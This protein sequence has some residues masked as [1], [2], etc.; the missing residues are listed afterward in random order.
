LATAITYATGAIRASIVNA[1]AIGRT[2]FRGQTPSASHSTGWG[3]GAVL[4]LAIAFQFASDFG[5]SASSAERE[6]RAG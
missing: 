6:F 2:R 4:I 1:S 3:G 5:T